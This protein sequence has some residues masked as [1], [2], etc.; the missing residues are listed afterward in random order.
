MMKITLP[1]SLDDMTLRT[2]VAI[3]TAKS[4][5][6]RVCAITGVKRK[7]VEQFSYNAVSEILD[8]YN[9]ISTNVTSR[10]YATFN[11]GGTRFGFIPDLDAMTFREHVD[12]EAYASTIW[13]P[14]GETD[15]REL[16]NLVAILFRPVSAIMGEYY[17]IDKYDTDKVKRYLPKL[18]DVKMSQVYG[19]LV[20]FSTIESELI[21]NTVASITSEIQTMS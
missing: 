17:E 16:P 12:L 18:L 11:L 21:L 13:L 8:L 5:V 15:Y 14:N 20:F 3:E 19:A 9:E 2:Y 7:L 4:D 1:K 10:H 6:D